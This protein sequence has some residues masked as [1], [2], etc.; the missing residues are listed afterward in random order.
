MFST[1]LLQRNGTRKIAPWKTTPPE[2][3]PHPNPNPNPN[4]IPWKNLFGGNLSEGNFS[5]TQ[6]NT[7][8][9]QKNMTEYG[10]L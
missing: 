6:R 9:S 1:I 8:A 3:C 5:V 7:G 4:P 2:D 10:N